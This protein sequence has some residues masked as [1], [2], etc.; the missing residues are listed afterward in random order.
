MN[1]FIF[2]RFYTIVIVHSFFFFSFSQEKN[3]SL[4]YKKDTLYYKIEN[5]SEKNKI[6]SFIYHF[7]FRKI[8]DTITYNGEQ[9]RRKKMSI[10][11]SKTIRN[12]YI[13]VYD[14][15]GRNENFDEKIPDWIDKYRSK[16]HRSTREFIVKNFLLFS[17]GESFNEQKIYESERL[18]RSK[19]FA[20]RV[21]IYP[22]TQS[23]NQDSVDISVNILD[24][25]SFQPRGS[26]S[27]DK[28]GLG[29]EDTNL[30]GL[31]QE[32]NFHYSYSIKDKNN[33]ISGGY[34]INNIKGSFI[35]VSIDGKKD[36]DKNETANFHI[37]RPF[38]SPLMRW[39]GA[40]NISYFKSK[41]TFP[42]PLKD[43]L[44]NISDIKIHTQDYWLGYQ[45]PI[46][47]SDPKVISDNLAVAVRYKN[48]R[49]KEKPNESID[50][51]LFFSNFRMLLGSIGYNQRKYKILKNVFMY[52]F[53]EDI[54]YGK[55]F[56]LTLGQLSQ[57]NSKLPYMGVMG[58]YGDFI[59]SNYISIKAQLG[60][61][62]KEKR[63]NRSTLRIDALY[64]SPL[65]HTKFGQIRHFFSPT[66]V[67]G[68]YLNNTYYNKINLTA[69]DEFP[70]YDSNYYGNEKLVLRYQLQFYTDKAWKNF[71]FSPYFT[72]S[73][74]WIKTTGNSLFKNK[75]NSKFGIGVL[76]N[77]PFLVFNNFQFS[78]VYYPSVPFDERSNFGFNSIDNRI[79]PIDSFS[80]NI[81]NIVNYSN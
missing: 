37:S 28:I 3:D 30:F 70:P 58:I 44:Y 31:G 42:S 21:L 57:N 75:T 20:N 26:L 1:N 35:E 78:F 36:F 29:F 11:E 5:F 6:N 45:V 17:S 68:N 73:F 49:F 72:T 71:H 55:G 27:F 59:S 77:N 13:N 19:R 56:S 24:S 81:P 69:K 48:Y 74:G 53:S 14:P 46:L 2:L 12:I 18:L 65:I 54:P 22:I 60:H 67:L 51:I 80:L 40:I 47:S 4:F 76:V 52:N 16:I 41:I 10:H 39:A 66:Y 62:F 43:N 79:F 63:S 15:Y 23:V 34:K 32:F 50:P 64:F 33:Y 9:R 8:P 61:F 38:F 25:W 7:L